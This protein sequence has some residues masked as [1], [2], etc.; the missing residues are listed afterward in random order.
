[1]GFLMGKVLD[2]YV[3]L[4]LILKA[5]ENIQFSTWEEKGE[6]NTA[7]EFGKPL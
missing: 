1:M 4:S 2:I 3:L 7:E 5:Q 6:R